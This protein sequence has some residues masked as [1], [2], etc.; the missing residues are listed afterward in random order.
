MQS[1]WRIGRHC[2]PR[3]REFEHFVAIDWSGAA[4]ARQKG[5]CVALCSARG[6]AP[7]LQHAARVW[8]RRDVLDWLLTDM[9]DNTLVGLD[10]SPALPFHDCGSY[11]PGW[12][13]SPRDARSLWALVDRMSASDHDFGAN[14]FI[15]HADIAPYF[16][17]HGNRTGALFGSAGR[18][19]LRI[20]E[21]RQRE[22][23]RLSP[24][25]CFNLVGAA[26][27]GKSSLTGMRVLHALNGRLPVW[28]FDPVPATG[29]VIAEIYTSLAAREAGIRPGKAK[30]RD[31]AALDAALA[32]LGCD[33]HDR[34]DVYSDHRTDAILTAAW[35]RAVAGRDELWCPAGLEEVATTEGWTFGIC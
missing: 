20:V 27:V 1:G 13:Q 32:V 29:S 14:Q 8:S 22:K 2:A 18:G 9:P 25:S 3:V 28:P 33:P 17:R 15:D 5:I 10:L 31:G 26:Q 30:M 4:G 12:V 6:A 19:R 24:Y 16:R 21:H 7:A 34:L 11:F 35:L 23:H